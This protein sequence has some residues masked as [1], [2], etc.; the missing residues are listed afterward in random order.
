MTNIFDLEYTDFS[1]LYFKRWSIEVFFDKLKNYVNGDYYDVYSETELIKIINLQFFVITVTRMM[2]GIATDLFGKI[3][4]LK[5][6]DFKSAI[7]VTINSIIS[8]MIYD[9]NNY[10]KF[11]MHLFK[12]YNNQVFSIP[13]RKFLHYPT[14]DDIT[15]DKKN[16][17]KI[18]SKINVKEKMNYNIYNNID[19]NNIN[20]D[21]EPIPN[22]INEKYANKKKYA[23][24]NKKENKSEN[25]KSVTNIFNVEKNGT[26]TLIIN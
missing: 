11:Y 24:K 10:E 19:M 14:K 2:I 1:E 22:I 9:N 13:N 3:S 17:L 6:I 18:K 5:T 15:N 7:R 26:I 21:N 25:K 20:S 8:D 4:N 23:N 16:K 12:I